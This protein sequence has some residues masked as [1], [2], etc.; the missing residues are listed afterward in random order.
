MTAA[1]HYS[2]RTR[3]VL[4]WKGIARQEAPATDS[5]PRASC[6]IWLCPAA[7]GERNYKLKAKSFELK[8]QLALSLL[9]SL[10]LGAF[11][12]FGARPVAAQ[13]IDHSGG[14]AGAS[15][16]TLNGSATIV[17]ND[18]RLTPA[19]GSKAGSAF[20][21][22]SEPVTRFTNDFTFL[23]HGSTS[24][25]PADGITFTWQGDGPT[26]LGLGGG[27]L[28][29]DTIPK[30]AAVKFDIF[31]NSGEGTD[32]TGL[33][34]NGAFPSEPG[35]IDL[36]GTGVK[37]YGDTDHVTMN[38]DSG[39]L[40]VTID[41]LTNGKSA[42]QSYTVDIPS[43]VGGSTAFVGFTGGTGADNAVQ[44]IQSWTYTPVP[45]P[46]SLSLLGLGGLPLVRFL[47]RRRV[48]TA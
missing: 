36:S 34:T 40:G 46:C 14:F 33:F 43:L 20:G 24:F 26:A 10:S 48:A 2:C 44:D 31:N 45:E 39:V 22:A 19:L 11:C 3:V 21:T 37:L 4:S 30:S 47:R 41:D 25:V 5:D 13:T 42:S 7:G 6:P 9:A 1:W 38:Y 15:D 27:G 17:G 35:A 23:L 18:L 32:S 29:Y 12:A 8:N 16:L 28:G